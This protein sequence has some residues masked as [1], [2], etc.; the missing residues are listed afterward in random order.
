MEV[1]NVAEGV[2]SYAV[3]IGEATPASADSPHEAYRQRTA[4]PAPSSPREQLFF[5]PGSRRAYIGLAVA[6]VIVAVV[7]LLTSIHDFWA[8]WPIVTFAL[9]AGIQWAR[10]QSRFDRRTTA[11][12]VFGLGMVA[13]NLLTGGVWAQWPLL[14][15][16]ILIAVRWLG[17]SR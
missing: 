12:I 11:L 15:I 14:A 4:A 2:P 3:R 17:F 9:I 13:I 1:K 8:K 7:N 6:A 10:T 16:A 5:E